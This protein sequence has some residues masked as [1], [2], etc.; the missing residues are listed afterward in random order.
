M[1]SMIKN[2]GWTGLKWDVSKIDWQSQGRLKHC[3]VHAYC[4]TGCRV[5]PQPHHPYHPPWNRLDTNDDELVRVDH[6]LTLR[7]LVA[8]QMCPSPVYC[9]NLHEIELRITKEPKL[10]QTDLSIS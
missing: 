1:G 5:L 9:E 6:D 8:L 10:L 2:N 3:H 4:G 7:M